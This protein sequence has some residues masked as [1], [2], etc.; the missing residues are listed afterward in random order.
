MPVSL[1]WCEPL[2]MPEELLI[3]TR[4]RGKLIEFSRLLEGLPIKVRGLDE[5]PGLGEVEE[6]GKTF[7]ENATIKARA[8]AGLTGI[9]TLADDSG[10]QVD[11]LDGAPGI[12]SAR[13]AGPHANDSERIDLLLSELDATNDVERRAR[14]VCALAL[15]RPADGFLKLFTGTCEGRIASE[16]RGE[17]GFGY[18][19][20]FI[21]DGYSQSFGEL[22]ADLKDRISHRARAFGAMRAFL[23]ERFQSI[24]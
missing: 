23:V 9:P 2:L 13:Y 6:D 18:D 17:G 20:V 4:N 7:G 24:T 1:R 8:C 11:A 15:F 12:L 16:P 21:P 22:P 19:P 10:L 5:F 3:A 14:F